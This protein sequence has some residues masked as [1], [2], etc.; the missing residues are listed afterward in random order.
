MK[1]RC[2]SGH[3]T[4]ICRG[5]TRSAGTQAASKEKR[6][7]SDSTTGTEADIDRWRVLRPDMAFSKKQLTENKQYRTLLKH[8]RHT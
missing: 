3:S 7:A 1:T 5:F 8:H 4:T 2:F 6:R